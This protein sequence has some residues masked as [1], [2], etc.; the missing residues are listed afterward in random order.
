MIVSRLGSE[1][2]GVEPNAGSAASAY[3]GVK[4]LRGPTTATPS[5]FEN[6][7]PRAS[8]GSHERFAL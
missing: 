4:S 7:K 5:V 6:W 8:E 2:V 3:Q 1:D